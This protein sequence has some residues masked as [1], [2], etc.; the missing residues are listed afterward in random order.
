M[1]NAFKSETLAPNIKP[2]FTEE[3]S[4]VDMAGFGDTRDYIGIIGVSYFLKKVTQK[5][6]EFKFVLVIDEFGMKDPTG[7][8]LIDTFQGFINMFNFDV[9]T[10]EIKEKLQQSLAFVVTR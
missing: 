8:K 9:M 2:N 10:T 1:S 7:K 4:L 6:K 5:V 3:V